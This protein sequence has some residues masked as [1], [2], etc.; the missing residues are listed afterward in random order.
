MEKK[1]TKKWSNK[2]V[3]V[4]VTNRVCGRV[5]IHKNMNPDDITWISCNPNLEVEVL[6][7]NLR[8]K[9]NKNQNA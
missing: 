7:Y 2:N 3:T 9:R 6:E 1:F 4:K 5:D 8:G